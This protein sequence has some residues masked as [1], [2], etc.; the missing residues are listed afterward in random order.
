MQELIVNILLGIVIITAA[1]L[2]II[3]GSRKDGMTKK[4]KKMM[5]R[6]LVNLSLQRISIP[7]ISIYSHRRE[8][9]F[10]LPAICLT[11]SLS[12]MTF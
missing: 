9:G 7:L 4:Q 6:I 2:L 1:A 8:T 5:I 3:I 12:A 11:I 10:A